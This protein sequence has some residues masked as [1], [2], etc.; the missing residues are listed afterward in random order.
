MHKDQLT[1][2]ETVI[3]SAMFEH[4]LKREDLDNV[5]NLVDKDG[6]LIVHTVVC[7]NVPC[8]ADWFYLRP[9]VHTAFHTNKSMSIL[10]NQWGYHS[11]IYCP[12]SKSWVM[13]KK[14]IKN[15]SNIINSIN[16]ELQTDYLY[17]KKGFVDYWKGF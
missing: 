2:Y 13:L 4:I 6:C 7:E 9:P 10:M 17:Y 1:K 16:R 5:N 14:D 15:I 12:K 8:D 3:N 11:S